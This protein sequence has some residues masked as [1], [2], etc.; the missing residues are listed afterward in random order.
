MSERT[1]YTHQCSTKCIKICQGNVRKFVS[2]YE[3]V[4]KTEKCENEGHA[5]GMPSQLIIASKGQ[6]KDVEL[7]TQGEKRETR[8]C[9][10]GKGLDLLAVVLYW[11][12]VKGRDDPELMEN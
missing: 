10:G 6:K 5:S 1:E 4:L 2:N 8:G 3:M 12:E 9:E 7:G 11:P